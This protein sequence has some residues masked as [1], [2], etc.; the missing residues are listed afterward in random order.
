MYNNN[1]VMC[2]IIAATIAGLAGMIVVN[3][4]Q[5]NSANYTMSEWILTSRPRLF[6][7][8]PG[9]ANPTGVVLVLILSVISLCSMPLVRRGGCF[10]V[11][12]M[13]IK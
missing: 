10:E 3:D 5:L 7:L 13:I 4:E 1:T 6:G 9:A 8:V 2:T 11:T 12:M